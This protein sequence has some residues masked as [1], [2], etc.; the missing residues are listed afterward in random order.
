MSFEELNQSANRYARVLV[1]HGIGPEQRVAVMMP[2]SVD[3]VTWLLAVMKTGAAYVPVDPAHPRDRITWMLRDSDPAALLTAGG[4]ASD[5]LKITIIDVEGEEFLAEAR[6]VSAADLG[7]ADRV[8]CL[9]PENAVHVF[10]TSGSTGRPKGVIVTHATMV[11]ALDW[12]GTRFPASEG[13][14]S[15]SRS[16]VSFIDGSTELWGSLGAGTPAVVAGSD[17]SGDPVRLSALIGEYAATRLR[18]VPS[19]AESMLE[20]GDTAA[21]RSCLQWISSGDVLSRNLA[22]RFR[23]TFPAATLVNS[24]G[25]TECGPTLVAPYEAGDVLLSGRVGNTRTLVLDERLC[26]VE[27][28]SV[29]EAYV[30]GIGVAR[31]Y[32]HRPGL[33]AERFVADPFGAPGERMYR[34]GDLM[35]WL[36]HDRFEFA[37]RVDDQVKIRGFRVEPGEVERCVA[38]FA[39]VRQVAVVVREDR[40]GDRRLVA[41]VVGDGA[42]AGDGGRV[43]RGWVAERLPE[44]MVPSVVVG[45]DAL[46]LTVNGKLDR[47]ALPVPVVSGGVGRGPRSAREEVLCGL[48]AEVL[49]VGRVGIDEG[50]FELGGHSLL[51]TRLLSRVRSVLGAEVSVRDLFDA[52]TVAGLAGVLEGRSGVVRP[53]LVPVVRPGRVPLSFAQFRLWFLD[54]FGGAG[55]AYHVP[56]AW[57]LS[58]RVDAGVL[59]LA[60]RD[61]VVRH[62]SLRTVFPEVGEEPVQRVVDPGGLGEL[63]AVSRVDAAEVAAR[64]AAVVGR[65][66]DL[67]ADLPVRAELLITG[68][69][70]AGDG[71]D[72]AVLVV[73]VHHIASDGWS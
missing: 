5:E 53:G 18:L 40:P 66:F 38:G 45:V 4:V 65:E 72:E 62:E 36:G 13:E 26:P 35:R 47:G 1:R 63:L 14:W 56:L 52:P 17:E 59:G 28:G 27:V 67:A 69:P 6:A 48:F 24:Y 73:V 25:T 15:C 23:A 21:L 51:A 71:A 37:G 16:S 46:P 57:R 41:Y 22:E 29:G 34:T 49:G 11:N 43:L 42:V 30:A 50:F 7:D 61:V 20:A 33:T 3:M 2:R 8:T 19:L 55:A 39:G 68:D 64:V 54:R 32:H 9:H 70:G 44:Y 60:L 10:Y 58:G 31:G 12:L